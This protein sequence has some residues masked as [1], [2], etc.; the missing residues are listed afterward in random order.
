VPLDLRA[1]TSSASS[2]SSSQTAL[3]V[4]MARC[5]GVCWI[6]TCEY[7]ACST[8]HRSNRYNLELSQTGRSAVGQLSSLSSRTQWQR[9]PAGDSLRSVSPAGNR[10]HFDLLDNDESPNRPAYST[11][12]LLNTPLFSKNLK[13]EI[14]SKCTKLFIVEFPKKSKIFLGTTALYS[15]APV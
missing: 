3:A 9:L 14:I 15:P 13:H 8:A 6:P 1:V 12:A 4:R 5:H 11:G 2:S 7:G 10:C